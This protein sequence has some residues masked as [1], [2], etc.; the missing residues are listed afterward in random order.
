MH[1]HY[2][3][4]GKLT[5]KPSQSLCNVMV[6]AT[7]W[8]MI[9]GILTSIPDYVNNCQ[10]C[11]HFQWMQVDEGS[12][13]EIPSLLSTFYHRGSR[14]RVREMGLLLRSWFSAVS[15]QLPKTYVPSQCQWSY[16]FYSIYKSAGAWKKTWSWHTLSRSSHSKTSLLSYFLQL[17]VKFTTW[18]CA[19]ILLARPGLPRLQNLSM[20]FQLQ[21]KAIHIM[22]LRK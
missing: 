1:W 11:L 17:E 4:L 6:G 8:L 16:E 21:D 7:V 3:L 13:L 18:I 19:D 14:L 15:A 2:R 22:M 12:E 9:V 5:E 20:S 10:C